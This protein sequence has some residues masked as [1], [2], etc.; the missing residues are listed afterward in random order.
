MGSDERWELRAP[1]VLAE[2]INGEVVAVDLSQGS[3]YSLRGTA[4]VCWQLVAAG[5]TLRELAA[6]LAER[7]DAGTEVIEAGTGRLID[8]L[9]RAGV[10]R[11][12]A[13]APDSSPP[14]LLVEP[15]TAFESPVFETFHDMEDLLLLDPV[16][17]VDEAKGWP[18]VLPAADR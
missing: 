17:D 5:W 16:H 10:L 13:G 11:A 12:R 14:V 18:H 9:V 3:Y 15:G 8:E 1:A 6:D 2:V 4:A 7:Y